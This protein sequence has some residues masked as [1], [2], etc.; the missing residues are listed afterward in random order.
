MQGPPQT[1]YT[2]IELLKHCKENFEKVNMFID[3]LENIDGNGGA[4]VTAITEVRI[5]FTFHALDLTVVQF[6]SHLCETQMTMYLKTLC[7]H[8]SKKPQTLDVMLQFTSAASI[9]KPLCQFLEDWRYD[10]DQGK[11]SIDSTPRTIFLTQSGEY[12]PVYDEFGAILTLILAFVHRYNLHFYDLDI[13]QDSFVAQ[14]LE[15]GHLSMTPDELDDE[16]GRQLGN[17]LRGL[18]DSDKDGL[19]NEVFS[20]CRP[21]QFYLIVPTLFSQTVYA[22]YADVLSL[23]SVKGGLE[24][25]ISS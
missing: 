11:L 23:D 8:L 24:C 25:K 3:E 9:L 5:R 22:C 20:S 12:Q 7:N 21:Q 10:G 16:Q 13:S 6:L 2:K 14:L 1:K 15:R 19:S 18:Y 4:I 17:W